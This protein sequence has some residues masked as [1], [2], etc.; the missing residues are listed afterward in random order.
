MA[1][2]SHETGAIAWVGLS[3]CLN[4]LSLS[5]PIWISG[6]Q[7]SFLL[8]CVQWLCSEWLGFGF[9][10]LDIHL[11]LIFLFCFSLGE[12]NQIIFVHKKV[13]Q[14][15]KKKKHGSEH[16]SL[17]VPGPPVVYSC[18]SQ[19]LSYSEHGFKGVCM[20]QSPLRSQRVRSQRLAASNPHLMDRENEAHVGL[21]YRTILQVKVPPSV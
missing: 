1:S 12:S 4:F 19:A 15:R 17:L 9:L 14:H 7:L 20:M 18:F 16:P 3:H 8:S 6:Q 11:S 5:G 13:K 2:G 10:K 21:L